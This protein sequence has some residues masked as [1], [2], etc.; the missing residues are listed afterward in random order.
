[1]EMS[2]WKRVKDD[3]E[4][5]MDWLKDCKR[6]TLGLCGAHVDEVKAD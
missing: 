5:N 2:K 6:T 1:M 4:T 3:R